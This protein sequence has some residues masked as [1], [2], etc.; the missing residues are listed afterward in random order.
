MF[1]VFICSS[2]KGKQ[3]HQKPTPSLWQT[4]SMTT[5]RMCSSFHIVLKMNLFAGRKS[6]YNLALTSAKKS[7]FSGFI[8]PR[9]PK[10]TK[11]KF[12]PSRAYGFIL[13]R[14]WLIGYGLRNKIGTAGNERAT[15]NLIINSIEHI[16]IAADLLDWTRAI[17]VEYEEEG[18]SSVELC[19]AL[20]FNTGD[21]AMEMP[22]DE[23]ISRL[24][25]VWLVVQMS[26]QGGL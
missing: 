14:Q 23:Q 1:F 22:E 5:K 12:T 7:R 21:H 6:C 3:N 17:G 10:K 2:Q 9:C 25:Q 11:T 8:A 15:F 16:K 4:A 20:A 26:L 24:K 19:M 18:S 13:K